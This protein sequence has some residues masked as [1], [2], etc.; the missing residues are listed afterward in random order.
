MGALVEASVAGESVA[1]VAVSVVVASHLPFCQ[2]F[3]IFSCA[4][5]ER[6][7]PVS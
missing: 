6:R 5:A 3:N 7:E 4:S 1:A 2:A